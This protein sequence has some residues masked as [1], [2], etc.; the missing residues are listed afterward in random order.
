MTTINKDNV[1]QESFYNLCLLSDV[2]KYWNPIGAVQSLGLSI[3]VD[4]DEC[5]NIVKVYWPSKS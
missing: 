2:T 4:K 1:K 3:E 5:G